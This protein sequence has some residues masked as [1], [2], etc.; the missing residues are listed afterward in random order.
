M[1]SCYRH[2]NPVSLPVHKTLSNFP[3]FSPRRPEKLRFSV[4]II[5]DLLA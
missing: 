4:K 5:A 1:L 2:R 3:T